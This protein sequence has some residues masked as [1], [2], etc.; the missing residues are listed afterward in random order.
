[1]K[2]KSKSVYTSLSGVLAKPGVYAY[3]HDEKLHGLESSRVYVYIG[4]TSNLKR[5]MVQHQPENEKNKGLK[6]Y[7]RNRPDAKCW[8][9]IMDGDT[10]RARKKIEQELIKHF[11]PKFNHQHKSGV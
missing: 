11:K 6:I 5:R 4:E 9:C 3:G 7:L 8:Y 10:S 2:W 1:M